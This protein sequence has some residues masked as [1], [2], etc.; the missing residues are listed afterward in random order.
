MGYSHLFLLKLVFQE[1]LILAFLGYIPGYLLSVLLYDLTRGATF[2]PIF[3]TVERGA[4]VLILTLVMCFISGMIAIR[5][6]QDADPA[7]IF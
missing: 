6:L 7:D 2:L 1:A 4:F 3:M 5:K